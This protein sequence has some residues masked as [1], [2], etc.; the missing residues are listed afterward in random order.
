[1]SLMDIHSSSPWGRAL[2]C[3]VWA[4]CGAC[5]DKSTP[6]ASL[7]YDINGPQGIV[8]VAGPWLVRVG[9]PEGI[10]PSVLSLGVQY[11]DVNEERPAEL[12]SSGEESGAGELL[13]L[14]L[15]TTG[16]PDTLLVLIPSP[17]L[18]VELNYALYRGEDRLSAI[19]SFRE[20]PPRDHQSLEASPPQCEVYI[21]SP[22]PKLPVTSALDQ[23]PQSGI[24]LSFSARAFPVRD[25]ALDISGGG[26]L[27]GVATFEWLEAGEQRSTSAGTIATI[28]GGLARTAPFTTPLGE[29]KLLV[30]A[31]TVRWGRCESVNLYSSL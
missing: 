24:Q 25:G 27:M 31:Y 7:M 15:L 8:R 1:M 26:S 14:P 21:E 17:E 20:L 30:T 10:D 5:D 22:D 23:A 18:E 11:S 2:L 28:S 3:L 19:Y 12:P 9:V 16:R 6:Q 29:Q 4:L 13:T